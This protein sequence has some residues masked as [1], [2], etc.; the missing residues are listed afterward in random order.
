MRKSTLE[1]VV[2]RLARY[3]EDSVTEQTVKRLISSAEKTLNST[4]LMYSRRD[5]AQI[6]PQILVTNS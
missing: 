5:M 6:S 1:P 3:S 4:A 2:G